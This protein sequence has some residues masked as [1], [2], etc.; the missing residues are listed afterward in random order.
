ML[1]RGR[2]RDS[3]IYATEFV[4]S[5]FNRSV[6]V[7]R[8]EVRG[9]HGLC[10]DY[11][12]GRG[13]IVHKIRSN[14]DGLV[15]IKHKHDPEDRDDARR[16]LRDKILREAPGLID[17]A[18]GWDRAWLEISMQALDGITVRITVTVHFIRRAGRS[19]KT[20]WMML[21]LSA[22]IRSVNAQN[23]PAPKT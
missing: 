17:D 3:P 8:V 22:R 12:G 7:S 1:V 6:R 14:V 16:N 2:L 18:T 11:T 9:L 19:P 15:V 5:V 20:G 4:A 23:L 10:F 13:A 21:P